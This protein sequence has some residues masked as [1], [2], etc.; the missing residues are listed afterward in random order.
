M[1]GSQYEFDYYDDAGNLWLTNSGNGVYKVNFYNLDG[2]VTEQ[3]TSNDINFSQQSGV[4]NPNI[5]QITSAQQVANLLQES[6]YGLTATQTY[7][8]RMGQVIAQ[9]GASQNVDSNPAITGMPSAPPSGT[10]LTMGVNAIVAPSTGTGL[11]TV[12]VNM[13]SVEGLGSGDLM[14]QVDYSTVATQYDAI[15]NLTHSQV[16]SADQV[17]TGSGNLPDS[18]TM[19]WDDSSPAVGTVT[20]VQ[21][22]KKDISGQWVLLIDNAAQSTIGSYVAITEPQNATTPLTVQYQPADGSAA[23]TT[24]AA[25]QLLN[26]GDVILFNTADVPEGNYNYTVTYQDIGDT[27]PT[28]H[29][30]GTLQLVSPQTQIAQL[31]VA[32]LNRAPDYGSMNIWLTDYRNGMSMDQIAQDLY[33]GNANNTPGYQPSDF[34]NGFISNALGLP[35]G[36]PALASW[37]NNPQFFSVDS[38]TTGQNICS[39]INAIEQ[40]GV[41]WGISDAVQLFNNKVTVGKIYAQYE[42][43]WGAIEQTAIP[44]LSIATSILTLVT[45]TD[46]AAALAAMAADV[47]ASSPP[48]AQQQLQR[49]ITE[50]Y[51]LMINRP[52]YP[53]E[54]SGWTQS[55]STLAEIAQA[56]YLYGQENQSLYSDPAGLAQFI[57]SNALDSDAT[58]PGVAALTSALEDGTAVGVVMAQ[59]LAAVDPSDGLPSAGAASP[60]IVSTDSQ[61][62]FSSAVDTALTSLQVATPTTLAVQQEQI[63]QLYILMFDRA[64]NASGL[65]YWVSQYQAGAS[66]ADIAQAFYTYGQQTLGLYGD[67]GLAQYIY[68]NSLGSNSY[69]SGVD[70][71]NEALSSTNSVGTVLVQLL[72]ALEPGDNIANTGSPSPF[73]V[74]ADTQALFN[75]KVNVGITYAVVLGGNDFYVA[76]PNIIAQVTDSDTATAV[77]AALA[78]VAN[79]GLN[80]ASPQTQ[81]AQL[82]LAIFGTPPDTSTLAY[83]SNGVQNEGDLATVASD[84]Y[85]SLNPFGGWGEVSFSFQTL[86]TNFFNNTLDLSLAPTDPLITQWVNQLQSF[87]NPTGQTICDMIN[88]VETN[89]AELGISSA[90]QQ[91]NNQV[92][93]AVTYADNLQGA[94]SSSVS[95]STASTDPAAAIVAA[96]NSDTANATQSSQELELAQLYVLMYNRAPDE[97]GFQS[98]LTQLQA[99]ESLADIAQSFFDFGFNPLNVLDTST[100]AATTYISANA[101]AAPTPLAGYSS[102]EAFATF[103]YTNVLGSTLSDPGIQTLETTLTAAQAPGGEGAGAAMVNFLTSIQAANPVSGNPSPII[104]ADSYSLFM[105]KANV[106]LTYALALGGTDFYTDAVDALAPVTATNT[107]NAVDAAIELIDTAQ[108]SGMTV[109]ADATVSGPTTAA[110]TEYQESDRWGNVLVTTDPNSTSITTQ[111][112]Y[113]ANNQVTNTIEADGAKT[114]NYYDEEGHLIATKDGNGNVNQSVYD[115]NGDLVNV[116]QADGGV[117]SYTYDT[118]GDRITSTQ[119][120]QGVG[121][122]TTTYLFNQIGELTQSQSAAT[123]V[124]AFTGAASPAGSS[125][126]YV[127]YVAPTTTV[128]LENYTYDELGQRT[129]DTVTTSGSS[130]VVSSTATQYD[131]SGNVTATI[132]GAGSAHT[133]DTIDSYDAFHHMISQSTQTTVVT[134]AGVAMKGGVTNTQTWQV[135]DFGRMS[136]SIDMSGDLTT[137]SYDDA[138]HLVT[139]QQTTVNPYQYDAILSQGAA[140]S[141]NG[142]SANLLATLQQ[143]QG[144]PLAQDIQYTYVGNQLFEIDDKVLNQQTYYT[145][146]LDGNI[147]SEQEIA[148]TNLAVYQ[149][150]ARQ[151][152]QDNHITY[153]DM[154]RESSIEDSR[155]AITYGYDLDGNRV[156]VETQYIADAAPETLDYG[157]ATGLDSGDDGVVAG[158]TGSWNGVTDNVAIVNPNGSLT[159]GYDNGVAVIGAISNGE[160]DVND[161]NAFDAMNRETIVDGVLQDANGNVLPDQDIGLQEQASDTA[162]LPSGAQIGIDSQQGHQLTYDSNGDQ[163][164]DTYAGNQDNGGNEITQAGGGMTVE[165][166]TYDA[167]GQL[168]TVTRDGVLTQNLGYD[169][170]GHTVYSNISTA[171]PSY[172]NLTAQDQES[173]YNQAGELAFETSYQDSTVYGLNGPSVNRVDA[174]DIEYS[175]DDA[176][177]LMWTSDYIRGVGGFIDETYYAYAA[178]TSYKM[179]AQDEVSLKSS[180]YTGGSP[181]NLNFTGTNFDADGNVRNVYSGYEAYNSKSISTGTVVQ[182]AQPNVI[183][184]AQG[185]ILDNFAGGSVTHTLIVNDQVLGSSGAVGALDADIGNSFTT[186]AS[187]V[188]GNGNSTT[189]YTTQ[190]AGETFQ[191]IAQGLWGDASLWYVIADANPSLPSVGGLAQGTTITLPPEPST[192]HNDY[193]TTTPYNPTAA[194][195]APTPSV[196]AAVLQQ[197]TPSGLFGEL[198]EDIIF[199][200][201]EI[202][203]PEFSSVWASMLYAASAAAVANAVGQEVNISDGAQQHFS[204]KSLDLSMVSA[205]VSAGAQIQVSDTPAV[206]YAANAAI[207]N[208]LSQGIGVVTH[209]QPHFEWSQVADAGIAGGVAGALTTGPQMIGPAPNGDALMAPSQSVF[210]GVV[211]NVAGTFLGNTIGGSLAKVLA[212]GTETYAQIVTDSFGNA[213]ANSIAATMSQP[214]AAQTQVQAIVNANNN[215]SANNLQ[216]AFGNAFSNDAL[217]LTIGAQGS[218]APSLG[219]Y[220]PG[221][222]V[223]FPNLQS[224]SAGDLSASAIAVAGS[225][226]G[227][228]WSDMSG[229]QYP[230][231][232]RFIEGGPAVGAQY[233]DLGIDGMNDTQQ[234]A[235]SADSD[236]AMLGAALSNYHLWD[237]VSAAGGTY[238]PN[239][240]GNDYPLPIGVNYTKEMFTSA[241]GSLSYPVVTTSDGSHLMYPADVTMGTTGSVQAAIAAQAQDTTN[242]QIIAAAAGGEFSVLSTDLPSDIASNYA[243]PAGTIANAIAPTIINVAAAIKDPVNGAIGVGHAVTNFGP[244]AFNGAVNLTKMIAD[245]WTDIAELTPFA[246]E[247]AFASFRNSTPYNIQPLVQ[248]TGAAQ[249]GGGFVF[250]AGITVATA[251]FDS[252]ITLDGIGQALAPK[253]GQMIENYMANTGGL[254]YAAPPGAVWADAADAAIATVTSDSAANAELLAKVNGGR[255]PYSELNAA[256]GELQGYNQATNELG[257]IGIQAPGNASL[258]GPDFVTLDTAGDGT[259]NVWDAKYRGPNASYYPSSIPDNT[260]ANWMPQVTD[261]VNNM[262]AGPLQDLALDALQ[263]GRVAGRIFKWPQ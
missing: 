113:N 102:L 68:A 191:T 220:Q 178:T 224:T 215:V 231:Y 70:V 11:N 38:P 218:V 50:L 58:D 170:A 203:A 190:S 30:S 25:S 116:V 139:Q 214:S 216:G 226:T 161:W 99:G 189:T 263:N 76:A 16:F 186:L 232:L 185:Q 85:A 166:Y 131:L 32:I 228:P 174:A 123:S 46:T 81:V 141:G 17:V 80:L 219:V 184:D 103:V 248:D 83:W 3:V 242:S 61:A 91:F 8:N 95:L 82:Y 37:V 136:A 148:P 158:Y 39:M 71:L 48:S 234:A 93:V 77:N 28:V 124:Y 251:G 86:V 108:T 195:G 18:L 36:A 57:Y 74:S 183:N 14:V 237:G 156:H 151:V 168:S 26:F 65:A 44:V 138:G 235:Y 125:A 146:D 5:G 106:A 21:V 101:T 261:S 211:G 53:T 147:T 107:A 109:T 134:A 152:V 130:A 256:I 96:L 142:I 43:S 119:I 194:L 252:P 19:S 97:G 259:I 222:S 163:L 49:E 31:Y 230:S 4:T 150:Q 127:T 204:S 198:I 223:Q 255:A 227:G 262:P 15:E 188:E 212:G 246:S 253:A 243:G 47:D 110:P 62:F 132:Q 120:L 221:Q 217:G 175:Y 35:G 34:I 241:D 208:A 199:V 60:F 118:F 1:N 23:P 45:S 12:T 42:G 172:F 79:V 179:A 207:D 260:L 75:N 145:Y 197:E 2:Q 51:M 56:I 27:A 165:R 33:V 73:V 254:S 193:Q 240:G 154:G 22:W 176:G 88:F 29:D 155:Y 196:P 229:Q 6:Y 20:R 84:M 115:Q 64:P 225:G 54:L 205:A 105:N 135:N 239:P 164:S 100:S 213:I 9:V 114:A 104:S 129:D 94:N 159:I 247:G 128:V 90:V 92:T 111:Y 210:A 10:V 137:Y 140:N 206:Q 78:A 160:T 236:S 201:A 66:L 250:N 162:V 167:L 245:G 169:A 69:D 117:L 244:N 238:A 258:Q 122:A 89:A 144:A 24:V 126:A 209:L 40:N 249:A 149:G 173:A 55:G 177:N 13:S 41:D 200:L 121:A 182:S 112:S 171:A 63:T 257:Q 233:G 143:E 52:P 67:D 133:I 153:D 180:G 72:A 192:V 98:W 181:S 202:Y 187:S 59:F 7:Y 157:T 87:W